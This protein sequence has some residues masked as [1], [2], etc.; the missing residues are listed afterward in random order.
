MNPECER[1]APLIARAA[2]GSLAPGAREALEAHTAVCASCRN[3]IAEQAA[4]SRLLAEDAFEPVSRGFAARVRERVAPP[5]SVFDLLNWRAWALRL[6]PVTALLALLAWYP[7][8]STTTRTSAGQTLPAVLDEWAGTQ[9]Q[10]AG[11]A[12]GIGPNATA[13]RDAL[14]AAA[15]GESSR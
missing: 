14:L 7:V 3:A 1:F 12:L 15:L 13:D 10:V 8:S 11:G 2:D 4:V 6:V 5:P 9:A